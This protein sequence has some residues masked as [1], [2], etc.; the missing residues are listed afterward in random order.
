[1]STLTCSLATVT[2]AA[3]A[4]PSPP[5]RTPPHRAHSKDFGGGWTGKRAKAYESGRLLGY[6]AKDSYGAMPET[7]E[8]GR[9]A[10]SPVNQPRHDRRRDLHRRPSRLGYPL[11]RPGPCWPRRHLQRSE[12]SRP[13]SRKHTPLQ[14][15]QRG[16]LHRMTA[17]SSFSGRGG[18]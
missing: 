8:A 14:L 7:F 11:D 1:M 6:Q 15:E 2:T 9:M 5:Q 12:G 10:G 18:F 16:A 13:P 17:R 3:A 4:V